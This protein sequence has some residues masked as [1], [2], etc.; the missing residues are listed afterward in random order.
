VSHKI[1]PA[2]FRSWCCTHCG[3]CVPVAAVSWSH[4]EG[5]CSIHAYMR[6]VARH[7][8]LRNMIACECYIKRRQF[9]E[10]EGVAQ[11]ETTRNRGQH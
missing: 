4:Y 3:A 8:V 11:V 10:A 6:G 5:G 9:P 7:Y 2:Q 1:I